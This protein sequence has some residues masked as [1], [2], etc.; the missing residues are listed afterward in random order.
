[1]LYLTRE[2]ATSQ[3][4]QRVLFDHD[5]QDPFEWS[6]G[7]EGTPKRVAKM[8]RE[9]LC[10]YEQSPEEILSTKFKN[11]EKYDQMIVCS[12]INFFSTCEHHLL[13]FYGKAHVGYLVDDE[14]VG[15]S[16]LA[17]IVECFA[18]RLQIQE[19][20]T[21]QIAKAIDKHL[22]PL[23]VGVFIEATHLCMVA[24]GVKQE[25]PVMRTS[26]LLGKFRAE[27]EV[28]DEF[29]RMCGK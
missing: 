3:F 12:G 27:P 28:R 5:L 29:F 9:L 2:N 13:P 8:W 24:R 19:R 18:R 25:E 1:M 7:M 23:G 26:A 11:E 20:M 14:V 16:K 17:R 21:M 4:I 15:L 6:D 10:G 22:S